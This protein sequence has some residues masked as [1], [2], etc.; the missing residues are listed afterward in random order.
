MPSK[1]RETLPLDQRKAESAAALKQFPLFV[2]IIC[3]SAD[4]RSGS[5]NAVK[6]LV[7][8]NCTVAEFLRML[9]RQERCS[10]DECL[11]VFCQS[12]F[13]LAEQKIS[14]LYQECKDEDG[15]LYLSYCGC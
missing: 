6:F 12:N 9:R 11:Y 3:E 15:F 1:F 2:P 7:P 5:D 8:D 10:R 13:P 4:H 14:T